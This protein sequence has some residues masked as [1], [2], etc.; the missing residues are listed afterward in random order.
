MLQNANISVI[1][2]MLLSTYL[3]PE[4]IWYICNKMKIEE[5]KQEITKS[6]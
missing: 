6:F 3:L 2:G 5:E 4:I 1:E